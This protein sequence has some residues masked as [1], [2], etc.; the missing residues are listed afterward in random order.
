MSVSVNAFYRHAQAR[1]EHPAADL[2]ALGRLDRDRLGWACLAIG[3]ARDAGVDIG[4][5]F[6]DACSVVPSAPRNVRAA[7]CWAGLAVL[8][9]DRLPPAARRSLVGPFCASLPADP[10][11][12]A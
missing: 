8:L 1:I 6:E 2:A 12:S 5:F 11:R 9:G 7:L 4:E 10:A 3:R